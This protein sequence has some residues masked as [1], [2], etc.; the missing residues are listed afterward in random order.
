MSGVPNRPPTQPITTADASPT[1]GFH[2][3]LKQQ[4]HLSH[5]ALDAAARY[6]PP[7]SEASAHQHGLYDAEAGSAEATSSASH[8]HTNSTPTAE[9]PPPF[10]SH[11]FPSR[12][13]PPSTLEETD[14]E[15]LQTGHLDTDTAASPVVAET[16][17]ALPR[18]TKEGRSNK[19]SDEAEP[20]PPYTAG[21]SPLDGFTYAMAAAGGGS[22]SIITQVQQTGPAPINTAL[23]GSGE[24]NISLDLR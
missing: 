16:K 21:S 5:R 8:I 7:G 10:S 19:T 20:P 3:P 23:G 24:E 4:I 13:F 9:S 1:V 17:A 11:N 18:D 6:T 15:Y 14:S 2:S 22:A 12:Y